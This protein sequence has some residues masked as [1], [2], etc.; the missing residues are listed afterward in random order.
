VKATRLI[1]KLAPLRS[2]VP[3]ETIC[4]KLP[5]DV[6]L[7]STEYVVL[8][9]KVTFAVW[10]V[11]GPPAPGLTTVGWFTVRGTLIVPA[12]LLGKDGRAEV[13]SGMSVSR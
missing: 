5:P 13:A 6:P 11:P 9:W 10:R 2:A 8:A 7:S 12:P 3:L 4:E 1:F